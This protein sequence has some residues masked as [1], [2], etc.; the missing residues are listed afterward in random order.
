MVSDENFMNDLEWKII[1]TVQTYSYD[2]KFGDVISKK[3]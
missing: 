1:F 2:K 3:Y